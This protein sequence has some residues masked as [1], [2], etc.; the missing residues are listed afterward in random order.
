MIYAVVGSGG[1]TSL[2]HKMAED[3]R[4]EG[5]KVFVT[6]STHMFI[7]EDTLLTDDADVIIKEL[8]EKGYCMAGL[9]EGQR[10]HS[11]SMETYEKVCAH[12]DEVLIEADGS[13]RLP[14][15]YPKETEPVIWDNVDE[16]LVVC[17]LHAIGKTLKDVAFR[18]DLVY[19]CLKVP[20]VVSEDAQV[21]AAMIQKLVREGYL[22][23]LGGKYPDKIIRVC[24]AHLDTEEQM[25]LAEKLRKNEDVKGIII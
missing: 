24:P 20:E 15:K 14:L 21:D 13:N 23:N 2:V 11:L 10:I 19:K 1:K 9:P 6:T 18:K 16:I 4:A 8:E 17:A 5:K 12:A 3:F 7:E 22:E 25:T